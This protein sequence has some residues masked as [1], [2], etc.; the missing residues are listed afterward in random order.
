VLCNRCAEPDWASFRIPE[1]AWAGV[2]GA[3]LF[4]PVFPTIP[5]LSPTSSFSFGSHSSGIVLDVDELIIL[6]SRIRSGARQEASLSLPPSPCRSGLLSPLGHAACAVCP[7]ANN[8]EEFGATTGSYL[9]RSQE[10]AGQI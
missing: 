8:F 7:W 1:T 4:L 10:A 5:N 3:A 6:K 9:N 2:T